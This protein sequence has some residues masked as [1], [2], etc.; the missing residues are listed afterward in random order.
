M[1]T[2]G[3]VAET[4]P[5]PEFQKFLDALAEGKL[6]HSC[7]LHGLLIGAKDILRA[8]FPN[9]LLLSASSQLPRSVPLRPP[10][11]PLPGQ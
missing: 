6:A 3:R 1:I 11:P 9:L 5:S 4:K 2:R 8:I 10:G 7:S